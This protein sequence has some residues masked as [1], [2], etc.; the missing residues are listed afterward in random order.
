MLIKLLPPNV[1]SICQPSDMEVVS[2]T[3]IG[4]KN[5]YQ[6]YLM[7]IFDSPFFKPHYCGSGR[8]SSERNFIWW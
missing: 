5:I 2:S 3:E 7:D 4:Y 6:S 8:K 1:A